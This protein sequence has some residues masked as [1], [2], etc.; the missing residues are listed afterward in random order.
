MNRALSLFVIGL[1]FGAGIG[2]TIA[3]GNGITFDGHDHAD[4]AQHA[5]RGDAAGHERLHDTALDVP[6]EDAPTVA[7]TVTPDPKAG[8]NLQVTTRNFAFA[9]ADAGRENVTGEGHA[10]LYVNGVK[11]SRLYGPWT[12]LD[13]LPEGEVEISVTLNT[14]DHRPIA[15]NGTPVTARQIIEVE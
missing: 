8:Y 5:S 9:P 7:I 1:V 15:V 12:H 11:H 2:F 10:H 3:A 4:P 14:N 13:G 6:A